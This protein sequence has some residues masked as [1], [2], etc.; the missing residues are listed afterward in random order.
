MNAY[1]VESM[2]SG[3]WIVRGTQD[4]FRKGVVL[5]GN[6]RYSAQTLRGHLIGHASTIEKAAKLV[7]QHSTLPGGVSA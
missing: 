2:A 5:G 6:G 3:Y 1:M 7:F 4:N